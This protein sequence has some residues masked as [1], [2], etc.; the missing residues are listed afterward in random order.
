MGEV[1]LTEIEAQ[2]L[3]VFVQRG[4]IKTDKITE[5]LE[6]LIEKQKTAL[7]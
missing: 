3:S 5:I 2:I 1:Y 4:I 7:L 6:N